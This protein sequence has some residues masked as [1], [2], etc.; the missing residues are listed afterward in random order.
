MPMLSLESSIFT[1][2]ENWYRTP[3]ALRPVEPSPNISPL[4][5]TTTLRQPP[6]ARWYAVLTPMM[7][8][9]M[10]TTSAVV[11]TATP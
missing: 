7:P 9:P 6:L 5:R 4:S 8:P 10:I 3:P 11:L 2:V 1:A